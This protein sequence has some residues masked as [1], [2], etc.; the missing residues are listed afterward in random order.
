MTKIQKH[1]TAK[2]VTKSE[3]QRDTGI[4]IERL[5]KI[6]RGKVEVCPREAKRIS[7]SLSTWV[8]N[9]FVQNGIHLT[10]RKRSRSK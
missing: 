2:S 8:P 9:V 10:P 3:L 5:N 1:M 6:I 4:P 7:E